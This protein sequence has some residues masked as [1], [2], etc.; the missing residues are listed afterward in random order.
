MTSKAARC[1]VP[2]VVRMTEAEWLAR[3][4]ELFGEDRLQWRFVCPSCGHVQRPADF[5]PYR[6][7]GASPDSATRVCIGLYDGHDDVPMCSGRSPCN[8]AAY[9]LL[10]LCPVVVVGDD[11]SEHQCFGFAEEPAPDGA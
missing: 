1:D 5:H 10:H 11:G 4:R 6:D 8:Y 2:R 7:E 3:G 9:G